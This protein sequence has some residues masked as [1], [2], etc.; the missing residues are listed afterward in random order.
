MESG[1]AALHCVAVPRC[2]LQAR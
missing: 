1:S 2:D